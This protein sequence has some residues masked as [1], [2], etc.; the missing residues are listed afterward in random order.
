MKQEDLGFMIGNSG[1]Q[2]GRIERGENHVR[3]CTLLQISKSHNISMKALY[4]FD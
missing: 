4:E 3:N 2:V 1:K